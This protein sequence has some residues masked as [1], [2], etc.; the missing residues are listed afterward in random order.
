MAVDTHH[1]LYDHYLSQ[2]IKTRDV[3]AGSDQVKSKGTLYL[4][5]TSGMIQDGM[6]PWSSIGWNTDWHAQKVG[7]QA[8]HA[9]ILRAVFHDF[10]SEAVR[11]AIG[12]MHCKPA[13]IQLPP[14]L[15][16]MRKNA[17]ANGEP[18]DLLLRRINEQQLVTGR[19]G[20]LLDLPT[21]SS[22]P[23]VP[24]LAL[25]NAEHILNWDDGRHDESNKP[26]LN[27]V[28]LCESEFER[29]PEF[30]WKLVNKYRVLVLGDP[31]I[32]EAPG[33]PAVAKVAIV[34]R[35]ENSQ[36]GSLTPDPGAYR[37]PKLIGQPLH[38]IPFVI[39]NAR[40][41]VADPHF[42]P[43]LGLADLAL[44]TY[45]GEADYRQN[46]FQQGQDT[47]VTVG[48]GEDDHRVGAGASINLKH[49]G[50]A[51]YIGV[52]GDG[53]GEMRQALAGDKAEAAHRAGQL[54]DN[55]ARPFESGEALKTR[56]AGNSATLTEIAVSGAYGLEQ[57]LKLQATWVGA[58]PDKVKVTPNLDFTLAGMLTQELVEMM[59]ARTMGAPLSE[60]SVHTFMKERGMTRLEYEEE[61][62]EIAKDSFPVGTGTAVGGAPPP[63]NQ[64]VPS[65]N[66][67]KPGNNVTG[68]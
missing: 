27:L 13:T 58:D 23:P 34:R 47:L 21:I 20:L 25:Y 44:A 55:R 19:C 50:E 53:L 11:I 65:T 28:I 18:L 41:V 10:F 43:L 66:G 60:R 40:D 29:D 16:P 38:E 63:P 42:P 3:Y 46:L 6:S 39:I 64:A 2:W 52:S 14:Q 22:G 37:V 5:A 49:G 57:I 32:N 68:Q 1:P 15:E 59:T 56:Q 26:R 4:P 54:I 12:A 24:Y 62:A 35:D 8:Y 9:Y 17:T 45:R 67:G 61:L 7:E 30:S 51:Y 48:S 31:E 36:E 33:Q